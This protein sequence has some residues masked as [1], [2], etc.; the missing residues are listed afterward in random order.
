MQCYKINI[1]EVTLMQTFFTFPFY[2]A[3]LRIAWLCHTRSSVGLSVTFR[4][5]LNH[6]GWTTLKIISS[7]HGWLA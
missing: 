2:H 3:M 5:T 4:Y 1:L 6:T 7:F